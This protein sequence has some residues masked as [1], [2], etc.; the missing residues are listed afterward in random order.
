VTIADDR[1]VISAAATRLD[2]YFINSV[3]DAY[4]YDDTQRRFMSERL[5][6]TQIIRDDGHFGGH[7]QSEETFELPGRLI[8]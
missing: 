1:P 5:G 7:G 3:H 8:A 6:G 4:G 2:L